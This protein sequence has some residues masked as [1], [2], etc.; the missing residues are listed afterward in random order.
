MIRDPVRG[1]RLLLGKVWG[2]LRAYDD[3]ACCRWA[4]AMTGNVT[5]ATAVGKRQRGKADLRE[6][7]ARTLW[8]RYAVDTVGLEIDRETPPRG[9]QAPSGRR[10]GHK[11]L[12]K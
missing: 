7:G 9:R 12:E 3:H 4:L 1:V 6:T 10:G 2:S 11:G 5:G 8:P